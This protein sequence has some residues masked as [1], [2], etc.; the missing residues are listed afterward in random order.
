MNNSKNIIPKNN[1]N[2][3]NEQEDI[4]LVHELKMEMTF[5]NIAIKHQ[6]TPRAIKLRISKIIKDKIKNGNTK[7]QISSLLHI[8]VNL[9]NNILIESNEFEKEKQNKNNDNN[10]ND[11]NFLKK[12]IKILEERINILEE[13]NKKII[14]KI[15]NICK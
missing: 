4:D 12:K 6:R 11:N 14:R 2:R 13:N 5:E 15:K 1:M 8:P 10:N 7:Q 3:W 9:I